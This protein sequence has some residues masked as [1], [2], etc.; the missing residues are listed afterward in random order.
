[1]IQKLSLAV[2][3]SFVS[4]FAFGQQKETIYRNAKDSMSNYFIAYKPSG[5][6]N[7]LLLLLTSFNETPEIASQET[8]IHEIAASKGIITIFAS[9]QMGRQTFFIDNVSQETI[10]ELIVDIQKKY[11]VLNKPLYLGGFSLGGSGVVKYA[12]RAFSSATLVRPN[13]IFSIDPP[14]DFERMYYSL[15]YTVRN[16]SVEISKAEANYFIE[17]IQYEFQSTPNVNKLPFWKIS[18]YSFSDT[19]QANVKSL[20]N[21]PI[22]LL[23]EPDII[24]QMEQRNRSMYDLNTLDCSLVI[25][26]LMLLGNKNAKLVLTQNKGFRKLTGRKNPHSWSIADGDYV[27]NWLLQYK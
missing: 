16:S 24:W 2:I 27:V 4:V 8:N 15:E 12:E 1:M 22:L 19:L 18:P 20:V 11:D 17:R 9:L 3:F 14:L 10:D 26:S 25:N 23:S 6:I 5:S 21:C 7:G 13:A